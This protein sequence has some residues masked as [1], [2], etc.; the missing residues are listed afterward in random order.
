M[1]SL[2]PVII[3]GL[4]ALAI[5]GLSRLSEATRNGTSLRRSAAS[6]VNANGYPKRGYPTA[7]AAR[8]AAHEQSAKSS[9]S[10]SAYKC[11]TCSQYHIGHASPRL[12]DC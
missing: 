3:I 11:S 7:D 12:G 8:F 2:V 5:F 1:A 10:L 6:H 9:Q 4:V